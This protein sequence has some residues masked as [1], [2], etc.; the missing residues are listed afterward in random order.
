MHYINSRLEYID[1]VYYIMSADI[2]V[3]PPL[4]DIATAATLR[5]RRRGRAFR[6]LQPRPPG[7]AP[8]RG[9][10]THFH[11]AHMPHTDDER[12]LALRRAARGYAD[13]RP[14]RADAAQ[15]QLRREAFRAF[16]AVHNLTAAEL[17]RRAGL[18]TANALY[19]FLNRRA[20]S[21]ALPTIE[22]ILR[23]CPGT[24]AGDI[25]G[26]P[27]ARGGEANDNTAR[28]QVLTVPLVCETGVQPAD[29]YLGVL[30][31]GPASRAHIS[32]PAMRA[33]AIPVPPGTVPPGDDLFA[34]RVTAPGAERLFAAG[35]L[36]VCQKLPDVA[37]DL[38]DGTLVI[39]RCRYSRVTRVDVRE[40][41]HFHDRIWLWQ[42]STHPHHQQPQPGPEPL[43]GSI[44]VPGGETITVIGVVLASWQPEAPIVT[45]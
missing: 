14:R 13:R 5:G 2:I 18:P 29:T 45:P 3:A 1:N 23:A 19:N 4:H 25:I 12:E 21:L 26:H 35:S 42:H 44:R 15:A 8:G 6:R 41:G 22:A 17:A 36:L 16:L 9:D 38:P 27:P 37:D 43:W 32:V 40:V 39:L 24:T 7:R 30:E 10:A 28:P 20:G 31:S 33:P 11:G 34:V